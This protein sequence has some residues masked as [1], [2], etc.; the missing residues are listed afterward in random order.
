MASFGRFALVVPK[1]LR[2]NTHAL[3]RISNYINKLCNRDRPNFVF[4]FVFGPE[5]A[6]LPVSGLFRIRFFVF[7]TFSFSAWFRFRSIVVFGIS[8][9]AISIRILQ[10]VQNLLCAAVK[11]KGRS[12]SGACLPLAE[13]E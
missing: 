4:V 6:D 8:E 11:I 13:R 1:H 2:L 10:T 5:T 9:T 7:G 3:P 12:L